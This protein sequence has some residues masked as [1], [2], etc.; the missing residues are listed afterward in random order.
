MKS[1]EYASD[2][3]GE[4]SV[5]KTGNGSSDISGMKRQAALCLLA[6]AQE[7]NPNVS[8]RMPLA[9]PEGS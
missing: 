5:V 7:T 6:S 3:G 8:I 2:M 9:D 1:R 4:G